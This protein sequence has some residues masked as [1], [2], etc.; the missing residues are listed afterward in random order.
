MLL[1]LLSFVFWR[2]RQMQ[3]KANLVLAKK[4]QDIGLQ[5]KAIQSQAE[6]LHEISDLKSKLFS[7]ISHDLRGPIN[8]LQALLDLLIKEHL[9]PVEF[10]DI[11]AKLKVSLNVS[12]RTLENLL[13][14]SL[15][16]MEGIK[17][18]K[19]IFN[20]SSVIAEV[21]NLTEETAFKKQVTINNEMKNVLLVEADVNQ[22]HLILRNLLHNAIKFSQHNDSVTI[23]T[24]RN[25]RFCHLSI[26]DTGIGMTDAEVKMIL[27]SHEYFTKSG[28]DQEKGTGLGLL[29][30]K[31]FIKRNGGELS[32]VSD[33]GKGTLV[34]FTLPVA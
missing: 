11:S 20:I 15:S 12:Q 17:T 32:I 19:T 26:K 7:V 31:D 18:E 28:T 29:L 25:G 34:T 8:N 21:V 3:A 22:V 13:N 30:C 2:L 4:N 10:K 16:Q 5:N 23:S 14:W 24:F 33:A 1:A 9:T 27:N 6:T